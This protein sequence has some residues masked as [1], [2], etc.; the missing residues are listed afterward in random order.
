M[1]KKKITNKKEENIVLRKTENSLILGG[2]ILK[3]IHIL[4]KNIR[5]R[6]WSQCQ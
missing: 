3:C 2:G 6:F 5:I 4:N 1:K